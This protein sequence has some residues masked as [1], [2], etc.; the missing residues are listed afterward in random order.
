MEVA[1]SRLAATIASVRASRPRDPSGR[2]ISATSVAAASACASSATVPPSPLFRRIAPTTASRRA[3][4][5]RVCAVSKRASTARRHVSRQRERRDERDVG[6]PRQQAEVDHQPG[7]RQHDRVERV[8]D[9]DDGQDRVQHQR[10]EQQPDQA[11]PERVDD[12]RHRAVGGDPGPAY[13]HQGRQSEQGREREDRA[14]AR[15]GRR[16][17]RSAP[18]RRRGPGPAST[19]GSVLLPA[20]SPVVRARGRRER[21]GEVAEPVPD[22]DL[23]HR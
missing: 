22:R 8:V 18:G 1:S 23:R 11:D 3:P 6:A 12:P 17:R 13:E 21:Q 14:H 15:G 16:R 9:A 2:S 20:G 10:D 7:D 19:A 5:A 4:T